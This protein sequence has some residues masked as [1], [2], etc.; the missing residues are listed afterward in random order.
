MGYANRHGKKQFRK[1]VYNWIWCHF[2]K[3]FRAPGTCVLLN[4]TG[5]AKW[6][7]GY[8]GIQPGRIRCILDESMALIWWKLHLRMHLLVDPIKERSDLERDVCRLRSISA[9]NTSPQAPARGGTP[10]PGSP[11]PPCTGL[12]LQTCLTP[13]FCPQPSF[14][15]WYLTNPFASVATQC[16]SAWFRKAGPVSLCMRSVSF[17]A[18]LPGVGSP[19]QVFA[20]TLRLQLWT[21]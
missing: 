4:L 15:G 5:R 2:Q 13:R 19:S 21:L 6:L 16:F 17:S 12:L 1:W 18:C 10:G 11:H 8:L 20:I 14:S 7:P 9:C 3:S